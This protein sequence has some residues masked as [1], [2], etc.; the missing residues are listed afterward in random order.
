MQPHHF[1]SQKE[2]LGPNSKINVSI[3]NENKQLREML[4]QSQ[5]E[6]IQ[7]NTDRKLLYG[8]CSLL[9]KGKKPNNEDVI[10]ESNRIINIENRIKE[11]ESELN[12]EKIVNEAEIKKNWELNKK[13]ESLEEH[14]REIKKLIPGWN[15]LAYGPS[16]EEGKE[17]IVSDGK[18]IYLSEFTCDYNDDAEL[19]CWFDACEDC[20]WWMEKPKL[21]NKDAK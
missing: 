18:N 20:D 11:L 15:N 6:N 4:F 10:A 5:K 17:Y 13:I 1:S 19:C 12:V 2:N 7:I 3:L 21:P 9:I 16:P 8:L 14:I